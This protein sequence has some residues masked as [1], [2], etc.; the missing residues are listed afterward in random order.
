VLR[1]LDGLQ[2][3][4]D[5]NQAERD[6]RTVK[7]RQ[8]CGCW[9]TL[10]GAAAFLTVRSHVSTAGKHGVDLVHASAAFQAGQP[11][12]AAPAGP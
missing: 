9:R 6:L 3:P 4:F 10:A 7:L 11:W 2:V 8:I 12:L 5:T 1:F